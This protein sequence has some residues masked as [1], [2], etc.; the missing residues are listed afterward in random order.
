MAKKINRPFYVSNN[1]LE[2]DAILHNPEELKAEQ[3][4]LFSTLTMRDILTATLY[5]M[6]N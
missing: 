6:A 1:A 5:C 2:S 3:V 4:L